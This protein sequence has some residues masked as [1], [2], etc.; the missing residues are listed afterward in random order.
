MPVYVFRF[1]NNPI[2]NPVG[3][4][5]LTGEATEQTHLFLSTNR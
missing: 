3:L 1:L 2:K 4:S 5:L